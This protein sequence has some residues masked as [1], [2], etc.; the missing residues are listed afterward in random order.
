MLFWAEMFFFRQ[1]SPGV[2]QLQ[3]LFNYCK[4]TF[5]YTCPSQ[6]TV[7][8][9]LVDS[10]M[11]FTLLL[12]YHLVF[13]KVW[14]QGHVRTHSLS[15]KQPFQIRKQHV[16][17]HLTL[18]ILSSPVCPVLLLC[19]LDFDRFM[20]PFAWF[21]FRN[22]CLCCTLMTISLIKEHTTYHQDL[23]VIENYTIDSQSTPNHLKVNHIK[24]SLPGELPKHRKLW[25]FNKN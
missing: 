5:V 25:S 11:Y 7:R 10:T 9:C 17:N 21:L 19:F 24:L 6:F 2:V 1:S 15:P 16:Q 8:H 18:K 20:K 3:F 12:L 14:R 22:A 4:S 23:D 13:R